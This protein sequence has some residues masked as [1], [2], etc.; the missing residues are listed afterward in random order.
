M[1]TSNRRKKIVTENQNE[2]QKYFLEVRLCVFNLTKK[3]YAT[4]SSRSSKIISCV[5]TFFFRF[6]RGIIEKHTTSS[7]T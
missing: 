3:K 7:Q 6:C 2:F 4:H 5:E 1:Q